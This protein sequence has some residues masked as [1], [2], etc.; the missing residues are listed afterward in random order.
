M[1]NGLYR[2]M[3]EARWPAVQASGNGGLDSSG[4]EV[5]KGGGIEVCNVLEEDSIRL[6]HALDVG[7]R[8]GGRAEIKTTP[9]PDLSNGVSPTETRPGRKSLAGEG[10]GELLGTQ[11]MMLQV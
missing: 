10:E 2:G 5:R 3:R 8:G 11:V 7:Y 9:R 6:A 1:W 4:V